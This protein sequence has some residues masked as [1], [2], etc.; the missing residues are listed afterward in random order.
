[1]KNCNYGGSCSYKMFGGS[2]LSCGY[3]GYCD[4]QAPKDSRYG[5]SS[6]KSDP[7]PELG[8]NAEPIRNYPEYD[9]REGR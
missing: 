5:L 8:N 6:Y 9:P 1:M 2:C 7:L 3:T 4:Y